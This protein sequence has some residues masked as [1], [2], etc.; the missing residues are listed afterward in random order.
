MHCLT[1]D[2]IDA[3]NHPEAPVEER[4]LVEAPPFLG[5]LPATPGPPGAKQV[6]GGNLAHHL[7]TANFTINWEDGQGDDEMAARAG[8]ALEAAWTYFVDEHGWTPPV[9]SDRF[10]LWVLLV[11]DLDATGFTTEYTTDLYPAGYPVI[12]L[13]SGWAYDAPF[14][15]TL[16]E[17]E[18]HHTLQYAVRDPSW[19]LGGAET[20]Y[21][22][23]SAT[24]AAELVE[25]DTAALDYVVPWYGDRPEVR[26]DDTEGSHQY[27]LFVFNAWLDDLLGEGP[28]TMKRVWDEGGRS[29]GI[30][31]DTVLTAV[32]GR[33][34]GELFG[35]FAE[36]FGNDAY[37]RGAAWQDPAQV[38]LTD[39]RT[40]GAEYLGT[41]Y[42]TAGA[43][44]LVT[45]ESVGEG[46]ELL[47]AP[48]S[49]TGAA[50]EVLVESG[51]RVAVTATSAGGAH[52][53]LHLSAA[54]AEDTGD[55]AAPAG[56][57][58]D[59]GDSA[60]ADDGGADSGGEA[61]G[62]CACATTPGTMAPTFL[63]ALAPIV[64]LRRRNRRGRV[65]PARHGLPAGQA[66]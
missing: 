26:F 11:T 19:D 30:T 6:Y 17:H 24:W 46:T 5:H 63:L 33:P 57:S 48:S 40:D 27:G 13:N 39:G 53:I 42:Y 9:S 23:A 10:Y 34:A 21:W 61:P 16:A 60:L 62:G 35:A 38:L 28:G 41:R 55:T 44:T 65:S 12:Y 64:A 47:T 20:W 4:R 8:E 7:E 45:V 58:G 32:T 52:W 49:P 22:E 36:A 29:P 2:A 3:S 31:W 59:T 66:P 37:A 18:F 51:E 54:P 25:P 43:R 14:W 56:D 15:S 50:A 1:P